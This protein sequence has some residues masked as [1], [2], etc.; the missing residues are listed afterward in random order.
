MATDIEEALPDTEKV[1]IVND[2]ILHAPP[3]EFRE[4]LND[5]RLLLN[6]DTLL[7]N[8]ASSVFAQ[9]YKDQLTPV[10]VDGLDHPALIT[11]HNDLGGSRYYDPRSKQSF[12]YDPLREEAS[13]LT[14]HT[15]DA[16]AESWRSA[17]ES[18]WATYAKDH[19][20]DGVA[21]VYG[22]SQNDSI[23]LTACIEDH[24]FNPKNWWNGRWRSTWTVTFN[25]SSGNAELKGVI[26]VQVHYYEDGNVQLVSSKEIKEAIVIASES[27]TAREFVELVESA[28]NEYQKAISEN[29]QA[30]SGTTFKALRRQLPVT[31]SKIDWSK[32]MSYRIGTELKQQ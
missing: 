16:T 2:F 6:N 12:K 4:V 30:M 7:H 8:K 18:L 11:E 31:R 17:L 24:Q 15:P 27:A 5:V 1:R 10:T 26:K 21:A 3:G 20:N 28:E 25:P 14:A 29:Y 23:T 22:S 13:D 32:I 19:Y 9:Y